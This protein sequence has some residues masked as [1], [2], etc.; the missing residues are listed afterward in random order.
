MMDFIP[1]LLLAVVLAFCLSL[2]LFQALTGV[3]PVSARRS[4]AANVVVLLK[5][6]ELPEQAII[7]DLGAGWG[8]LA[9]ALAR[10]FPR[11]HIVG[12]EW[13]PL[14]YLVGRLRTRQLPNVRLIRGNF[15]RH[16]LRDADA[17]TCYL[18]MK[19]MPRLARFLDG[20]VAPGTP[21]V[22]LAFWFRERQPLAMQ[23]AGLDGAALYRWAARV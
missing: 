7:Y 6:A 1:A 19:P 21:V 13:S 9:I 14:P 22:T 3:P 15:Y 8:S 12:I 20:A 16:D 2:L 10:A 5:Q 17:V 23:G 4:E 11:A 18:M